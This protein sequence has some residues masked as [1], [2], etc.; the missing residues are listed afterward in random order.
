MPFLLSTQQQSR[1]HHVLQD[2]GQQQVYSGF[3]EL[4][5]SLPSFV[6][7][8][9]IPSYLIVAESLITLVCNLAL[10]PH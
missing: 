4:Q 9:A 6:L 1:S 2:L 5:S 10:Q 8:V 7:V 3:A